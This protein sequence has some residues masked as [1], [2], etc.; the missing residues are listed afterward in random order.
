MDLYR[1]IRVACH[2]GNLSRREAT[3]RFGVDRKTVSKM[4]EHSELSG[5]RRA[6]GGV[7]GDFG[8]GQ[9]TGNPN[10]AEHGPDGRWRELWSC[11]CRRR[12]PL[13]SS[14]QPRY[15]RPV[16]EDPRAKPQV[17]VR[18]LSGPLVFR[19]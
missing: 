17:H 15:R 19:S 16:A 3:R 11:L 1:R 5:Y 9:D 10:V 14:T 4:L 12:I 13:L 8:L 6:D 7:V 2:H 18:Q